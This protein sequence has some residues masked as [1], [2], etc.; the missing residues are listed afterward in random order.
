VGNRGAA[1]FMTYTEDRGAGLSAPAIARA[2]LSNDE[3]GLNEVTVL[4]RQEPP[5]GR[6]APFR[7]PYRL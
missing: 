4:Y 6:H 7:L 3:I 1:V 2:A 5:A